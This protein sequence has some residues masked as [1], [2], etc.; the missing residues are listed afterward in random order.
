MNA[1]TLGKFFVLNGSLS[2][3]FKP[4]IDRDDYYSLE[5]N[6]SSL[7]EKQIVMLDE[8]DRNKKIAEA[9]QKLNPLYFEYDV[10]QTDHSFTNKRVS[11]INKVLTFLDK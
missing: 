6:I 5:K 9:I 1:D 11:L 10:W 8:H 2:D 7:K 4:V 3:R